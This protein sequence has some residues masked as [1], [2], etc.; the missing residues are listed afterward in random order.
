MRATMKA[1]KLSGVLT[2]VAALL[3]TP[4]AVTAAEPPAQPAQ[5][6]ETTATVESRIDDSAKP[7]DDVTFDECTA[8]HDETET[9]WFKNRFNICR[10]QL[11]E[12]KYQK[13]VNGVVVH[14]GSSFFRETVIGVAQDKK[15]E[16]KFG[17]SL[18]Y[19]RGER[20]ELFDNPFS[21]VL[22]CGNNDQKRT[23]TC[24]YFS[25][26][27]DRSVGAWRAAGGE[28]IWWTATMATTQVPTETDDDKKWQNEL[29]G[30][31]WFDFYRSLSSPIPPPGA[32]RTPKGMFRCDS[33]TYATRGSHCVFTGVV[34]TMV[35][36]LHSPT[37]GESSEFIKDAQEDITKTAPG[38][39]PELKVPGKFKESTVSYL[40]SG[41]DIERKKDGSR[42]K[43][44]RACVDEWGAKYTV[45]DG[46]KMQ[47]DEYPFASTYQNAALAKEKPFTFGVRRIKASHNIA[48]G[49]LIGDWYGR[50]HMLDGDQFYVVV[51]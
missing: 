37:Y 2:L 13:L 21:V 27:V 49:N 12:L 4:Q 26:P 33:A 22:E 42:R 11:L 44:R 19:I 39:D 38:N 28:P 15:G 14:V 46:V 36:D 51:R 32:S 17:Y 35:F 10:T 48:G 29:R 16:I 20:E 31:F 30:Y 18:K 7:V 47:C 34:P 23:S 41:Y 50:E 8:N 24:D 5:M 6:A 25:V 45:K 9:F 1:L 40:Y 3:V 43:V